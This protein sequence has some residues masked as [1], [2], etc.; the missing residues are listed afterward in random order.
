M[1]IRDRYSIGLACTLSVWPVLYRFGLHS[2]VLACTLLVYSIDLVCTLSMGLYSIGM[3]C[4]LSIFPVLYWCTL[5]VWACNLS[6]WRVL[7]RFGV[8]FIGLAFTLLVYS[9]GLVCTLLV[10]P[11]LYLFCL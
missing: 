8:Y 9:I 3:A 11:V 4:T 7:Y 1:C 5:S 6:V 10:G 2:N